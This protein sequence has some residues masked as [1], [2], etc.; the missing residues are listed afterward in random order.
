MSI[1]N[2]SN[3]RGFTLLEL[4]VSMAIIG[5]LASFVLSAIYTAREKARDTDRLAELRELQ[6]AIEFTYSRDGSYPISH[7]SCSHN[8]N[9]ETGVLA[10]TINEYMNQMPTDPINGGGGRSANGSDYNYC[11]YGRAG[12]DEGKWYMLTVLLETPHPDLD[13]RDGV[14]DC[15]GVTYDF[16]GDDGYILTLGTSCLNR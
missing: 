15:N 1:S 14:T 5:L 11:Y 12:G 16:G 8:S 4:I 13:S 6:A 3:R 10:T 2:L 9:W 7:W